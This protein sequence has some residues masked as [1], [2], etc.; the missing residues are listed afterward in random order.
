V[1]GAADVAG[2]LLER[3]LLSPR[4]VVDGSLRVEDASRLNRVFVVTAERERCFVLKLA[5]E[6][7]EMGVAQEAAVLERLRAADPDGSLSSYLPVL[8]GYHRAEGVL[9]LEAVPGARDLTR[10]HRRGRFSVALAREAGRALALVHTVEP[11]ALDGLPAG[12]DPAW[13]LDLHRPD[14][15]A[16]QTLSGAALELTR[17]IQRSEELCSWLE[18]LRVT[19]REESVVHGDVRWDNY[20]AL[21]AGGSGGWTRL[22]LIDWEMAGLGD[23]A[24]DVGAFFGEYLRMWLHSIPIVD[25]RAR[26]LAPEHARFPL[27]RMQP[28]MRA[29]WDAYA[30]HRARRTRELGPILDRATRFAAVRLLTAALEE[31]QMFAELRASLVDALQLSR[32]VLRRPHEAAAHLLG[33][34]GSWPAT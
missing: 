29:F 11:A 26:A 12:T 28:A 23:P 9:I 5:G 7:G 1:L 8:V 6:A 25:L 16:V 34:R 17:L 31:A 27:V 22:L 33:L 32:A 20:L 14:L 30:L 15:E 2:Y 13:Q 18:E 19:W 10:Q 4:A 21:R 3:K 24:A